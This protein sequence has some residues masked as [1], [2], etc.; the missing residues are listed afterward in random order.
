[1]LPLVPAARP[2]KPEPIPRFN[3]LGTSCLGDLPGFCPQMCL[4]AVLLF[5]SFGKM[6]K[7]SSIPYGNPHKNLRKS[8]SYEGGA[9]CN[10]HKKP[11][12][13]DFS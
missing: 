10:I 8:F 13:I 11:N 9:G 3:P 7:K 12:L 2:A 6:L 1:M 4:A 5:L